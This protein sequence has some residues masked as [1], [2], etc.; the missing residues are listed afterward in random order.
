MY[1][2]LYRLSLT[3]SCIVKLVAS[4]AVLRDGGQLKKQTSV[5]GVLVTEATHL[6]RV[7]VCPE[8][9]SVS[10]GLNYIW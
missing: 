1:V 5:E 6:K 7:D 8:T 9:G 10:S 3:G 2:A 4:V